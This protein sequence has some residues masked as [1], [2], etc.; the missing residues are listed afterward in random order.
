[1]LADKGTATGRPKPPASC[2]GVNPRGNSISASGLPR[3]S[4]IIRSSTRSSSGAGKTDSNSARA[5]RCPK[6]STWSSGRRPSASP[7]SRVA[8]TSAISLRQEAASHECERARRRT[9]EPLRVIDDAE[10]R[11]LLGGLGQ[12]P[13]HRQSDQGTDS[14]PAP[15]GVR[16]RRQARRAA[17]RAGAPSDRGSART[18]AEVPRTGAPSLPRHPR[19]ARPETP[20][21]LDRVL[22]QCRLADPRLSMHNQDAT[23]AAARGLEEPLEHL[24]L[25]LPAEQLPCRR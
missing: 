21:R 18:A 8:N 11:P 25:A 12:E 5:S 20:P 9:I 15:H 4:W 1:M 17:D 14:E 23:V 13:E 10:E 6:G 2:A 24:A 19:S 22:E 16:T 3:V 7:S